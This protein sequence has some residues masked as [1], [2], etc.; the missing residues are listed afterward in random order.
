MPVGGATRGGK[1]KNTR[2]KGPPPATK[3]SAAGAAGGKPKILKPLYPMTNK[4]TSNAKPSFM[5]GVPTPE[6]NTLLK[7]QE[8]VLR[9][10]RAKEV[11]ISK[12]DFVYINLLVG[13]DVQG[14]DEPSTNV[15]SLVLVKEIRE[16]DGEDDLL[17][18]YWCEWREEKWWLSANQEIHK[19]DTVAEVLGDKSVVE[20][21]R[22]I[23]YKKSVEIVR[24]E[25]WLKDL[26]DRALAAG[27]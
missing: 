2:K 8:T 11:T 17:W 25:G 24:T 16:Y 14:V 20:T 21:E 5:K 13:D 23:G 18:I 19:A 3:K 15:Q 1:I 26:L 27:T 12:L 9:G 22:V 4:G 7:K 10:P 6:W